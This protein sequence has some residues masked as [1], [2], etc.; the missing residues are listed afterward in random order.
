MDRGLQG[1][2]GLQGI[3]GELKGVGEGGLRGTGRADGHWGGCEAS[4]GLKR[5]GGGGLQGIEGLWGI[6]GAARWGGCRVL[7]G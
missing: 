3:W 7:A 6:T 2:E 1:V 4:G 5:I